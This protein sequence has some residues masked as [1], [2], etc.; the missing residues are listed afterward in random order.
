MAA[1]F[2]VGS[3]LVHDLNFTEAVTEIVRLCQRKSEDRGVVVTPNGQHLDLLD[4]NS[5]LRAV[6]QRAELV[7]P[8]GWPVVVAMKWRGARGG[9]RV[10]GADLLPALCEE[11]A[12]RGLS[13]GFIGG[14]PG[15]A[16]RAA[17]KLTTRYP[18]LQ[19]DLVYAPPLGFHQDDAMCRYLATLVANSHVSLLFL[20]LGAPKQELFADKWLRSCGPGMSIC[21]GAAIDFVAG[22]R[23][24]APRLWQRMG[25]EFLYRILREPRRLALRYLRTIPVVLRVLTTAA[26]VR[27]IGRRA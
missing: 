20:G 9:E 21:V 16:A 8:D 13:V 6:Y 18:G 15:V 12:A 19:V 27:L 3:A 22:E 2:Q 1:S 26:L 5:D 4:N 14:Q 11:A 25:C 24:R 17:D 23:H 7:L 10:T